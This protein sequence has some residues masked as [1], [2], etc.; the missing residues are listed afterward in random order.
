[1]R[2]TVMETEHEDFREAFRAFMEKEILPF[3]SEWEDA[4]IVP[5]EVWEKAGAAGFLCMNV[6][7]EFGGGGSDDYR[8]CAVVGEEIAKAGATGVGFSLHTDIVTPYLLSYATP[9]QK[10]RWLPGMADGTT[11][12]AI[13]MTEPGTG[14]DLSGIAT[15]AVRDGDEWVLNGQKVFI[16][17][18][19]NADLVVVAARTNPDP[20]NGLSLFVVERDAPG[21]TRGRNLDKLGMHAQDT[22]ELFFND[23]RIPADNLLGEEGRGFMYLVD[24]L[25]QE[26]LMVALG[27]IAAAEEILRQTVEYTKERKAFKRSVSAF[28]N[29][30]FALAEMHTEIEIGRIFVDRCID[31]HR[32][33]SGEFGI[34][35]AA[36]SKWW[37]TDL[38]NRVADRCLQLHGGYG[39][40]REYPVA[41]AWVDARVQAIYAGTNEIMKEIIG[42][43]VTA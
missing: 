5:R 17:N 38:L 12:S 43:H 22:A 21:F 26:R 20:H 31:E 34:I 25:P 8:F 33:G 2:R 19:I 24:K 27:S 1:M 37:T 40:M 4:G 15:S 14:S 30:R 10:R 39:Y 13:A 11:I 28:Q 29:T 32:N 35:E 16:T 3:H 42:R 18:G 7:E 6:P 23:A 41:R 36:E 9:E